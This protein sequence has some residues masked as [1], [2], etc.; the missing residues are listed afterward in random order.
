MWGAALAR[1]RARRAAELGPLEVV[2]GGPVAIGEGLEHLREQARPTLALFI[3]GMGARGHNFYFDL[4]S[5]YGYTAEGR[6]SRTCTC[7]AT[8]PRRRPRS[9]PRCWSPRP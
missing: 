2:A 6:G 7:Q 9:R 3:G 1:G 8:E 4:V 5:R